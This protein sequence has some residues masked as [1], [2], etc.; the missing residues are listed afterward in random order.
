V[1]MMVP[2]EE[3]RGRQLCPVCA[4]TQWSAQTPTPRRRRRRSCQAALTPTGL[5]EHRARVGLQAADCGR[6]RQA[7]SDEKSQFK[8]FLPRRRQVLSRVR[9]VTHRGR[10]RY[11][12]VSTAMTRSRHCPSV[13]HPRVMTLDPC[14]RSMPASIREL[15]PSS[16]HLVA[17]WPRD[18]A[19]GVVPSRTL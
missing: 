1:G 12:K 15:E 10:A 18:L 4:A 7:A 8:P 11:C 13:H 5:R 6:H 3:E 16:L 2:A 14:V 17:Y 19:T 9:S